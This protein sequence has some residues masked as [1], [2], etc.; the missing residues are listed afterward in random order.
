MIS[1]QATARKLNAWLIETLKVWLDTHPD[2]EYYIHKARVGLIIEPDDIAIAEYIENTILLSKALTICE[3][4]AGYGQLSILLSV[5]G[6]TTEAIDLRQ[7]RHEAAMLLKTSLFYSDWPIAEPLFNP[8]LGAFQEIYETRTKPTVL[9]ATNAIGF[10][11]L[12]VTRSQDGLGRIL[13]GI[14]TAVIDLGRLGEDRISSGKE[15]NIKPLEAAICALG[16]KVEPVA[17]GTPGLRAFW[18]V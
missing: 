4:A 3:M 14:T 1:V 11:S 12:N 6:Y 15:H 17:H 5:C 13:T 2:D 16:Y 18:K 8:V 7:D 9:V 10:P